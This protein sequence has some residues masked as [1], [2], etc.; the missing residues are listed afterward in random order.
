MPPTNSILTRILG[1]SAGS[2]RAIKLYSWVRA[3]CIAPVR[4]KIEMM[5]GG[6]VLYMTSS[7]GY[8]VILILSDPLEMSI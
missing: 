4:P 6:I 3:S 8:D 2:V 7:L 5:L 1:L